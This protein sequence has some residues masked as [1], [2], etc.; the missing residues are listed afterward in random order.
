MAVAM[1]I[2]QPRG[3][4]FSSRP[5]LMMIAALRIWARS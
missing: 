5:T 1:A 4:T 2:T 3:G